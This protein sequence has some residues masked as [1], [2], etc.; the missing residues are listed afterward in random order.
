MQ[1]VMKNIATFFNKGPFVDKAVLVSNE[2][3]SFNRH[4]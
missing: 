3:Y 1:E 2:I 4:L